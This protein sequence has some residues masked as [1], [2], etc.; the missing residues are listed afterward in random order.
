MTATY[1]ENMLFR[2]LIQDPSVQTGMLSVSWC[3]SQA[4]LD[5]L[6]ESKIA[7]PAVLI[8]TA[9]AGERY[10][11]SKEVRKLVPFKDGLTY[12]DFRTSGPCNVFAAIVPLRDESD[13]TKA[14]EMVFSRTGG[15]WD[16]D[17]LNQDGSGFR[18]SW[19]EKTASY[20]TYKQWGIDRDYNKTDDEHDGWRAVTSQIE[21]VVPEGLFA[22]EPPAWEQTWVNIMFRN[23]PIDQCDYRKRRLWAYSIQIPI[24]LFVLAFRIVAS[25][26]LM[27]AGFKQVSWAPVLRPLIHESEDIID[28]DGGNWFWPDINEDSFV[29]YAGRFALPAFSPLSL[30]GASGIAWMVSSAA[31]A[32]SWMSFFM[33]A[34]SIVATA[35]IV[36]PLAVGVITALAVFVQYQSRKQDELAK[37]TPVVYDYMRPGTA[38]YLSCDAMG[39]RARTLADVPREQRTLRLR[40]EDTKAKVCKPFSR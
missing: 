28:F 22:K 12:I 11:A 2:I 39:D 37:R 30:I 36:V 23:P 4:L 17:L 19:N 3:A 26:V 25:I 31:E 7:K 34:V 16:T 14:R 33:T 18:D 38:Q 8:V 15:E 35:A 13:F 9:P 6:A 10:H 40:F 20:A 1:G 27:L 5:L 29:Q 24:A 21:V 32:F